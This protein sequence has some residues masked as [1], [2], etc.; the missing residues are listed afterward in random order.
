MALQ[1]RDHYLAYYSIFF[2]S[3]LF[4][5]FY[6]S[7]FLI[8]TILLPPQTCQFHLTPPSIASSTHYIPIITN[9]YQSLPLITPHH[10]KQSTIPP[11][12]P[13]SHALLASPPLPLQGVRSLLA[14]LRPRASARD[15]HPHRPRLRHLLRPL[16][17]PRSRSHRRVLA[18][19]TRGEA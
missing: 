4:F 1:S 17:A 3:S 10:I 8:L 9:H 13:S 15:A 19:L 18:P 14:W 7:Y 12:H 11:H 16:L 5:L 2:S 6:C